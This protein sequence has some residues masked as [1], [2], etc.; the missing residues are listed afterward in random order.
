MNYQDILSQIRDAFIHQDRFSGHKKVI[1]FFDRENQF[2]WDIYNFYIR[3]ILLDW[4]PQYYTITSPYDVT[5]K[6]APQQALVFHSEKLVYSSD[7]SEAVKI[8]TGCMDTIFLQSLGIEKLSDTKMLIVWSGGTAKYSYLFL[9]DSFTDLGVVDYTNR[10]WQN[11]EFESLGS[12][13]YVATPDLSQYDIILLHAHVDSPY[14]TS[15]YRSQIKDG[16]IIVSYGGKTPERDIS[17]AFFTS[18]DIVIVDMY[19]NI[20]NLKP[21]KTA[22]E[23]WSIKQE[24]LIDLGKILSGEQKIEKRKNITV[25]ISGGTYIQN[26][27]MMKYMMNHKL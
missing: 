26:I 10:L 6:W 16:A 24:E 25:C 20:E 7:F 17:P 1:E 14:L 27:A 5:W 15:E 8:R 2:Q 23:S 21:L 22:I 13:N 19:A 11:H 18:E 3:E 9:R 12:M 4:S